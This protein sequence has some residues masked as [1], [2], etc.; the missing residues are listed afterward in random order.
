MTTHTLHLP[1]RPAG[2]SARGWHYFSDWSDCELKWFL[3]YVYRPPI[4]EWNP[5]ARG[6]EPRLTGRALLSG[7]MFHSGAEAWYRSG[8]QDGADTGA[9]SL[10]AAIAAAEAHRD[11]RADEWPTPEAREDDSSL[12]LSLLTQYAQHYGPGGPEQDFPGFK[13]IGWDGQPCLELD[14]AVDLETG[15]DPDHPEVFTS[16]LDAI[17]EDSRGLVWGME[18]KTSSARRVNA[19]TQ[20]MNLD[21]QVTGQYL[22][23]LCHFPTREIGGVIVNIVVKDAAKGKP[24]FVRRLY[25]RT[26]TQIEQFLKDIRKKVHEIH[27]ARQLYGFA[28]RQDLPHAL[29]VF[30]AT[31][32]GERCYGEWKCD[33]YE[34]CLNRQLAPRILEAD[35]IGR[36]R[37]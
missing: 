23:L 32:S 5:E 24:R 17:M 15:P 27:T 9:Y 6:V 25:S 31:P 30:D 11:E 37:T 20:R 21:G 12:I 33:F 10:D 29:A 28:N 1:T 34:A 3:K 7:S 18:H 8:W 36:V 22:Q 16:K 2:G 26:E 14:L 19:L 4:E 13:V 35:F